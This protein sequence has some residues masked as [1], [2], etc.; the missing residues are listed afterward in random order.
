MNYT[1]P[2]CYVV[3]SVTL[4]DEVY[5][6]VHGDGGVGEEEGMYV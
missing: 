3:F 1:P 6:N 2:H 5:T 4:D